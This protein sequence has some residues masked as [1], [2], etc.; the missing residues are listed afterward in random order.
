MWRMAGDM[1]HTLCRDLG[2]LG[3]N[4]VANFNSEQQAS[5]F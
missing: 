2:F 4:Q 3:F 1:V 5:S